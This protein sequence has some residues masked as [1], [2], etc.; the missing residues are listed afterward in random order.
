MKYGST[1]RRHQSK[2]HILRKLIEGV[3][4]FILIVVLTYLLMVGMLL[5]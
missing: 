1:Y 4:N 2:K 5:L 3:A